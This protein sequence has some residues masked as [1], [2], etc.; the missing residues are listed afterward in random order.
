MCALEKSSLTDEQVI[1]HCAM[2]LH[3]FAHTPHHIPRL[4]PNRSKTG[5]P[6]VWF[7]GTGFAGSLVRRKLVSPEVWFAGSLFHSV[8]MHSTR[9]AH[10]SKRRD[11]LFVV[12]LRSREKEHTKILL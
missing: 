7:A 4:T 5:S 3:K 11:F 10:R 2:H 12:G 8:Y 6:E 9:H 1:T